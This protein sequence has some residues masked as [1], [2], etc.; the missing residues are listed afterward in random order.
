MSE[1]EWNCFSNKRVK[2]FLHSK[3]NI[4]VNGEEEEVILRGCA[5]GNWTNPEGF[6]IGG[7]SEFNI[8]HSGHHPAQAMDRARTIDKTI[9]EL[10]GTSYANEFWP[11]WYR[12]FLGEEDIKAVADAG[13]NSIR[14]P[15]CASAFLK[16]EPG[17]HFIDGSF[18][19]LNDV[20]DWCEK[21]RIYAILDL[22]AAP[23]GQSCLPCDDAIDNV[24]HLFLD[25][26]NWERTILL[27][28]ELA[29]RYKD[30]WI[31]GAYE[32]LN[33][34]LSLPKWDYLLPKLSDFYDECIKRIRQ[35]DRS[36]MIIL[37]GHR[38]SNRLEIFTKNFDP[39]CSN[40][41]IS[42]HCYNA[43]P[44]PKTILPAVACGAERRVPVW[45]GETR[46]PNQWM[47]ALFEIAVQYH[48]GFN[49]F[50]FKAAKH[51]D[52]F[53]SCCGYNLPKD[54]ELVKAYVSGGPK[55]G[56]LKSQAI[57]DEYLENIK[58]MN[59]ERDYIGDEY[60][61]RRP[62]I[63]VPA[64]AYDAV[65]GKG[66]SFKGNYPYGNYF[67]YRLGD[68]TKISAKP[69]YVA[70]DK[71]DFAKFN[72]ISNVP[73]SDWGNIVLEMSEGDFSSY[74][75]REVRKECS[76]TLGYYTNNEV[77]L[78]IEVGTQVV[79]NLVLKASEG[80]AQAAAGIIK[81]AAIQQLKI[82]VVA[83]TIKLEDI[84]FQYI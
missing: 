26:E 68:E 51:K 71:G 46:G 41:A 70:L 30:R 29:I 7:V 19:M 2:G 38:F 10:C 4:M 76:I 64:V 58:F 81:P 69:G 75:I 82:T 12:N 14:L 79:G 22:H 50:T 73:R 57:F 43:S 84:S 47:T 56:Y 45:L 15:L 53:F 16:E 67:E 83:G 39:I 59:C 27:W 72:E 42:V 49:L 60:A 55:P 66:I 31:V 36:H 1:K 8:F 28:E 13:Y 23:G 32:L 20:L 6:M 33:E 11:K 37:E 65:P 74:T 63:T 17:V 62:G 61:L 21:Y 9:R 44:E 80:K 48:M 24:P 5:M 18:Q 35:I 52:K 34:P 3:D 25:D 78:L 77:A 40:W 54:W